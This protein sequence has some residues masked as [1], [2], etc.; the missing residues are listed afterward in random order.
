MKPKQLLLLRHGKSDWSI[1]CPDF[2]RPLKKRGKLGAMRIGTYLSEKGI[3]PQLVICSPANRTLNT[4][5]KCIKAMGGGIDQI[6]LNS[7]LYESDGQTLLKVL[8]QQASHIESILLVGHNPGLE[9]LLV[10]LSD[11]TLNPRADGKLLPTATLA[12]LNLIPASWNLLEENSC[13]LSEITRATDLSELFP[14]QTDAAKKF[15]ARPDYYYQ[16]SGVIAYRE[17][18]NGLQILLLRSSGNSHWTIPKGIIEPGLSSQSSAQKEALEEAGIEGD[19]DTRPIGQIT[20]EKWGDTC[21]LVVYP[22]RV[23]KD[24]PQKNQTESH[25]EKCWLS[26]PDAAALI[27][28]KDL[29]PL[30]LSLKNN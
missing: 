29:A 6:Q 24:R 20:I 3:F 12:C 4:A 8:K 17:T 15:R 30:I 26:L 23:R 14:T 22:V 5:E 28:N 27:A 18:D 21:S 1:E 19:I 13:T 25:R 2:D 7:E 10:F 9:D 11:T 16:Q